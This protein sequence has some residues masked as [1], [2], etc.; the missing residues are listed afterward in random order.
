[1]TRSSPN[2]V[3]EPGTRKRPHS[4]FEVSRILDHR[5]NAEGKFEFRILRRISRDP[6][7]HGNQKAIYFAGNYSEIIL[8]SMVFG[9]EGILH[10]QDGS[11]KYKIEYPDGRTDFVTPATLHVIAP[12]IDGCPRKTKTAIQKQNEETE[13][14]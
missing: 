11:I 12:E 5:T 1:M 13:N 10:D 6:K 4:V 14:E 7:P 3:G 9:I 8:N 2:A